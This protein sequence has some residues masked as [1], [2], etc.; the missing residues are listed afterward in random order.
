[1][2]GLFV[3]FGLSVKPSISVEHIYVIYVLFFGFKDQSGIIESFEISNMESQ[4]I[5]NI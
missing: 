3:N 4:I 1:M 5:E 2:F